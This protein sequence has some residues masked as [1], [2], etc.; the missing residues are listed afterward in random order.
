MPAA[1]HFINYKT[2]YY[3]RNNSQWGISYSYGIGD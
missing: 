1:Q 2:I 3:R